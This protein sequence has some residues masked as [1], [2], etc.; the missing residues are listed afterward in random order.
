MN[1][2]SKWLD[3]WLQKLKHSVPTYIKDG[4]QVLDELRELNI[5]PGSKLFT[6]DANSMYNNIDTEHSIEV[7]TWW[8]N[9][10]KAQNKLEF[11][12]PLKAVIDAMKIIMKNNIF[13]FGDC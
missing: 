8:L 9:D 6:C 3:H 7:I 4:Q 13:E 11:N 10:L 1:G 5:P 2:W 12:F